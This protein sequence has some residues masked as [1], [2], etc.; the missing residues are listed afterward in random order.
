MPIFFGTK[1]K[2]IMNGALSDVWNFAT[3]EIIKCEGIWCAHFIPKK[4]VELLDDPETVIA[5]DMGDAIKP[6]KWQYQNSIRKSP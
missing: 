2:Q 5:L 1:Q 6:L 4:A 3:I